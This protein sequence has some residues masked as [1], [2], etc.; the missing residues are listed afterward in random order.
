MRM[1]GR[2]VEGTGLENRHDGNVIV[3][4]NPTPSATRTLRPRL[5]SLVTAPW[6]LVHRMTIRS[7][8]ISLWTAILALAPF[9]G[10]A[11]AE[12]L[13]GTASVIDGGTIEI[14]GQ[15]IRL[16][17]METPGMEQLCQDAAGA[18]YRC[19]QRSASALSDFLQHRKVTCDWSNLDREGRR[20]ARCTVAGQD[21]GLWLVQ[22]GWAVPDRDC[23][24]ETYRAAADRAKAGRLGLWAGVFEMP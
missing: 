12:I 11:R 15:K 4:S 2:A 24:C 10:P 20:L 8:M 18:D 13:S 14:D 23:K 21:A 22:Q 1:G 5:A 16:L 9:A 17:D 19:G 7:L 3:G 6:H